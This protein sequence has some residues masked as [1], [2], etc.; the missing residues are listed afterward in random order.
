M[1]VWAL[2]PNGYY[3]NRAIGNIGYVVQHVKNPTAQFSKINWEIV[4]SSHNICRIR[5]LPGHLKRQKI[6]RSLWKEAQHKY[7]DLKKFVIPQEINGHN[8]AHIKNHYRHSPSLWQS[9]RNQHSRRYQ[10]ST[11]YR[12]SWRYQQEVA[13]DWKIAIYAIMGVLLLCAIAFFPSI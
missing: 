9:R 10:H 13:R 5:G 7:P 6:R 1:D 2:K 11:F 4:S 12:H 3:S 8:Q